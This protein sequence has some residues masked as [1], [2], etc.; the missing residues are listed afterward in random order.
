MAPDPKQ[1]AVSEK[2]RKAFAR[3][4]K[5][6]D[7]YWTESDFKEFLV[8]MGRGDIGDSR[9]K[10]SFSYL[11]TAKS[12]RITAVMLEKGIN[13]LHEADFYFGKPKSDDD[14]STVRLTVRN[15]RYP[16]VVKPDL[17]DPTL[18]Y[19]LVEKVG[20]GSYG[21][22]YKSVLKSDAQKT[23]ALK[24]IDLE[25]TQDDLDEL[26]YE[27]DFQA[28][29]F[30]PHLARYFGSWIWM[31]K[32]YIAMIQYA[33]LSEEQCA[34]ILREVLKGLDYMHSELR[35]HRDIKA[36]NILFDNWGALKLA[37]FGVA[38]QIKSPATSRT[39]FVGTPLYMAPEI[40]R[41]DP[42]GCAVD[43]WSVG[44][45]AI[46]LATGQPPRSNMHPMDILYATVR[47]DAPLL[48]GP[49]ISP[50]FQ[51]FVKQCLVKDPSQR[52]TARKLLDHPFTQSERG[53]ETLK[54]KLDK[55]W[56]KR[57]EMA[58]AAARTV[59]QDDSWWQ[60]YAQQTTKVPVAG[61]RPSA[62][63]KASIRGDLA[64][65]NPHATFG[66]GTRQTGLL[67]GAIMRAPSRVPG[68]TGARGTSGAASGF[69][70]AP[71]LKPL[72]LPG[73][74]MPGGAGGQD[75]TKPG[76]LRST[77]QSP[78]VTT[79]ARAPPPGAIPKAGMLI[80]QAA[81]L[82][83]AQRLKPPAL[84]LAPVVIT[85]TSAPLKPSEVKRLSENAKTEPAGA[86]IK[87]PASKAATE[88]PRR[89][90]SISGPSTALPP[91]RPRSDTGGSITSP[92]ST[93]APN[94]PKLQRAPSG[95][96][97]STA[98]TATQPSSAENSQRPSQT[99]EVPGARPSLTGD[100]QRPS[101]PSSASK[102]GS[103]AGSPSAG[104]MLSMKDIA[105]EAALKRSSTQNA[106]DRGTG[107]PASVRPPSIEESPVSSP[108]ARTPQLTRPG[109][110]SSPIGAPAPPKFAKTVRTQAQDIILDL[111]ETFQ[112]L[113]SDPLYAHATLPG[114][115]L[116]CLDELYNSEVR[117]METLVAVME[118]YV[119]PLMA[120]AKSR[121]ATLKE[122]SIKNIFA[123]LSPMHAFCMQLQAAIL[124]ALEMNTPDGKLI[125]LVTETLA[126]LM[127]ALEQLYT[128][129]AELF[130]LA[131]SEVYHSNR[132]SAR[133]REFAAGAEQHKLCGG[134]SLYDLLKAPFSHVAQYAILFK[135]LSDAAQVASFATVAA[136]ISALSTQM[137]CDLVNSER[138]LAMLVQISGIPPAMITKRG[139]RLL[140]DSLV[141]KVKLNSQGGVASRSP[142]R[143][144]VLKD[145]L[146]ITKVLR[147][148]IEDI[149]LKDLLNPASK[150]KPPKQGL[151]YRDLQLKEFVRAEA[152]GGRDGERGTSMFS[153]AVTLKKGKVYVFSAESAE[154]R[155]LWIRTLNP[156]ET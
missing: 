138:L 48:K 90:D 65:I 93:E 82:N 155:D 107:S 124:G 37:D 3:F 153:A 76:V 100:P 30:S 4:D 137:S 14:L 129:Y 81:L 103:S 69:M 97:P 36:E 56:V 60:Q 75:S 68:M 62:E 123:A 43:I 59:Q 108:V 46:E 84:G 11:D 146:V 12:G 2:T 142:I 111:S 63:A 44:I 148:N 120:A 20:E 117:Y 67:E 96:R 33:K 140:M 49:G 101:R 83:A 72:G 24:I 128:M 53:P 86:P 141:D 152:C 144:Y 114:T 156:V 109:S 119:R 126:E 92:I 58:G 29:C 121:S 122:E 127:P 19:T 118:V 35:I 143:L 47:E 110:A 52:A 149:D 22:I 77:L 113:F 64:T 132:D 78:S 41:G 25:K 91:A 94:I 7:G 85:D 17:S 150:T 40:V 147:D 89:S 18:L 115:F 145:A 102:G 34:Y 130:C 73:S 106:G 95:T 26:L 154:A 8:S 88:G 80:P 79:T 31:N 32:L 28:K 39:T 21:E 98:G 125:E 5:D 6:N 151:Q 133:F 105:A 57:K 71:R 9:T 61:P 112:G 42:Y 116:K 51:D 55:Y 104:G 10:A 136:R 45:L 13:L 50:T 87:S 139:Q 66:K 131:L 27:V 1:A 38:G 70:D 134:R 16:V 54:D 135:D 74:A 23:V 99:G 15:R